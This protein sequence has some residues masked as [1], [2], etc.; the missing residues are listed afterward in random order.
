MNKD[1]KSTVVQIR[2]SLE[3]LAT[4]SWFVKSTGKLVNSPGKSLSAGVEA[5]ANLLIGNNLSKEFDLRGAIDFLETEGFFKGLK[6]SKNV[7]KNSMRNT[8]IKVSELSKEDVAA[9]LRK[10]EELQAAKALEC[11]LS[12][13]TIPPTDDS[14]LHELE[15]GVPNVAE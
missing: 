1:E 6:V 12:D 3:N 4:I 15:K 7:F 9:A 5:F 11:T 10:F 2:I 8:R 13:F 14:L